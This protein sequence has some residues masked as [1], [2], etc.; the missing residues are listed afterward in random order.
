MG[1]FR[2][3]ALL[4]PLIL[5]VP[6]CG[7]GG[8]DHAPKT[9][10][11]AP[12]NLAVTLVTSGRV[13]LS[14]TDNSVNEEGFAIERSDSGAPFVQVATVSANVQTYSDFGLAPGTSFQYRVAAFN[15]RGNS[16]YAGP[17][18]TATLSLSWSVPSITGGPANGRAEHSAIYDTSTVPPR[19][20]VFGGIDPTSGPSNE[21]WAFSLPTAIPVSPWSQ[22]SP[23]G[24]SVPVISGHS[25]VYD[26]IHQRMVVFGG[27]TDVSIVNDVYVLDLTVAPPTWSKPSVS[28]TAPSPRIHHSAVFD[29][30]HQQMIVFGGND[31]T[32]ELSDSYLLDLSSVGSFSW[33]G[34]LF[35]A[36]P[37]KRQMHC[38][39]MDPIGSRMVVFGGL[40]NNPA[41][42]S[43]LNHDSWT[44]TTGAL[45]FWTALLFTGTPGFRE[46]HTGV[47][48]SVNQRMVVFGGAEDNSFTPVLNSD[49]WGMSLPGTPVWSFLSS[50]TGPAGRFSHSAIYD[51]A[52]S[53]MVIYGG[54]KDGLFDVLNDAWVISF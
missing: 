34:P 26:G 25:A 33:K 40:D 5:V 38:A 48:D 23:G 22:L 1:F 3:S 51:S 12:T 24:Y 10:P 20:L 36:G 45:P 32:S 41:D 28:G 43:A 42:G 29:I 9:P 21:L 18:S 8:N 30:V 54:Y 6:A 39:I 16:A 53:R 47:Y 52:Q 31:G 50:T 46:G 49:L 7:S 4:L 11:D 15:L 44:L 14:W 27:Q 35:A 2:R 13:D 17:V 37:L 19:M